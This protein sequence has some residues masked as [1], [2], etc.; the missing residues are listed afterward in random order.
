M[1]RAFLASSR[2][3]RLSHALFLLCMVSPFHAVWERW[4]PHHLQVCHIW[5]GKSKCVYLKKLSALLLSHTAHRRYAAISIFLYI[6]TNISRY[7]IYSL[8][9]DIFIPIS[10]SLF[11]STYFSTIYLSISI[12]L[13]LYISISIS[14]SI[15]LS[16]FLSISLFISSYTYL[17]LFIY[18]YIFISLFIY[19]LSSY[20]YLSLYPYYSQSLYLYTSIHPSISISLLLYIN[21]YKRREKRTDAN[22]E[23]TG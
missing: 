18:S 15:S 3:E 23:E 21:I 11:L 20:L 1:L 5:L 16:I 22:R 2:M 13:F 19:S 8:C 17:N 9:I 10:L 7:Y 12:H 6:H 4:S 14:I